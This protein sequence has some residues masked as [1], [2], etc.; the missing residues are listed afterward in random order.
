MRILIEPAGDGGP[1]SARVEI[2]ERKGRGHPDTLCDRA[3]EALSAA[4]CRAYL[5]RA[6]RVLHHNVDKAVLCGG[7]AR[8]ELGGGEVTRPMRMIHVG[9]ATMTAAGAPLDVDAIADAAT[10]AVFTTA[11]RRL[12][13]AR[14]LEV[15]SLLRPTS[16]ALAGLFADAATVPAANDTSIGCGFAPLSRTEQVVLAVERMLTDDR[17]LAAHPFLGEDVKV[18][19][20]RVDDAVELTV[21]V[22]FIAAQIASLAQYEEA[23]AAVGGLV[24]GFAADLGVEPARVV[25]NAADR[26][27]A[28]QLYLTVTG[29]SAEAGDDGQVGRGNRANGL[30]TPGR[31]MSLEA[32]AGKNPV[33]HV[34]KLYNAWATRLTAELAQR[35]DIDHA[36][37]L[38][39]SRIGAPITEPQVVWLSVGGAGARDRDG[40]RGAVRDALE[41][42]PAMWRE[43]LDAG[44][45]VA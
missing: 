18:L 22:A 8:A 7:S 43:L 16:S 10:R 39:A 2:V 31:P 9:R 33:S 32:M 5:E 20:V 21:A 41:R 26:P 4:L 42:L 1:A 24:R 6:G 27:A 34:G 17:T 25:V 15:A 12:D 38:L 29:S 35:P 40:L 23:R 11:L 37:C 36:T 14:H 13:A 28:G 19:A 3:A 30:I 45:P 44:W